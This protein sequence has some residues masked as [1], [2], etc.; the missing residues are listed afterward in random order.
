MDT[1]EMEVRVEPGDGTGGVA[2]AAHRA[3]EVVVDVAATAGSA[4]RTHA[5]AVLEASRATAGTAYGQVR[6]ASDQQL[7]LGTTFLA[8]MVAGLVLARVPR[9]LVLITLV[10][11]AVL[12]VGTA[13]DALAKFGE[14]RP[15]VMIADVELP[16]MNGLELLAR[17]G[18]EIREVPVIVITGKGS[19]ERAVAATKT[20]T[21]QLM[22]LAL[23]SACVA[24]DEEM[25]AVLRQIPDRMAEVLK[26][27]D[28]IAQA[29]E[30]LKS[31]GVLVLELGHGS[32]LKVWPLFETPEWTHIGVVHDLAG[33]PRVIAAERL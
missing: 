20:Y 4:V 13:E 17:L 31:T 3:G 26:M 33:I 22:A 24:E 30:R 9:A 16:G 29:A 21:S 14:F 25:L 18:E 19:E 32:L 27:S 6:Q 10:P 28:R 7:V 15:A 1:D 5:P 2:S 8:G 12:G 23:L 11:A